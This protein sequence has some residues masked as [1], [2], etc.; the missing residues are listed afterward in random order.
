MV[1]QEYDHLSSQKLA[2]PG[3]NRGPRFK[4]TI[5]TNIKLVRSTHGYLLSIIVRLSTA[6]PAGRTANNIQNAAHRD[7]GIAYVM[8]HLFY[9][10]CSI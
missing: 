1:K 8:P 9:L 7:S 10:S 6:R 4:L 5:S 3:K 2:V